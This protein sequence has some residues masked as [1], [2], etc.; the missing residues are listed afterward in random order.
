M[1]ITIAKR[2]FP[3]KGK[4][5][6]GPFGTSKKSS[7]ERSGFVSSFLPFVCTWDAVGLSPTISSVYVKF[8]ADTYLSHTLFTT[9]SK[10]AGLGTK[11]LTASS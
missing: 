8:N 4:S 10:P 3:L 7:S 2:S 6:S 5:A 1:G 11:F 9:S